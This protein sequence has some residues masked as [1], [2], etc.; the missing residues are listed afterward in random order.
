M[1]FYICLESLASLAIYG[2]IIIL[3]GLRLMWS[4]IG[5]DFLCFFRGL[6]HED[7][8]HGTAQEGFRLCGSSLRRDVVHSLER[9]TLGFERLARYVVTLISV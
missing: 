2:H 4:F 6:W 9:L 7:M 8:L 3:L 1:T 5:R